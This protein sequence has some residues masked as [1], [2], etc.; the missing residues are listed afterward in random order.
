LGS[1]RLRGTPG[2]IRWGLGVGAPAGKLGKLLHELVELFGDDGAGTVTGLPADQR[3]GGGSVGHDDMAVRHSYRHGVGVVDVALRPWL[4][5]VPVDAKLGVHRDADAWH[6]VEEAHYELAGPGG[7]LIE[8]TA[9]VPD[10]HGEL[11]EDLDD[12]V[13]V[14]MN[15]LTC[16]YPQPHLGR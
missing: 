4:L 11:I 6:R 7:F 14:L 13:Q 16:L 9:Q 12:Q 10:G 3:V 2:P 1:N 8:A 5:A 15:D